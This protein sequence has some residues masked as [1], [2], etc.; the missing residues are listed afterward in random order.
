MKKKGRNKK[1]V[2]EPPGGLS[3]HN[4]SKADVSGNKCFS[5]V[6]FIKNGRSHGDEIFIGADTRITAAATHICVFIS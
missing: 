6:L 3:S 5:I 2:Y 1:T 4:T